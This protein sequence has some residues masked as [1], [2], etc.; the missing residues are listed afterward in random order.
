MMDLVDGMDQDIATLD[1]LQLLGANTKYTSLEMWASVVA[2]LVPLLTLC[3]SRLGQGFQYIQV[4]IHPVIE[5]LRFLLNLVLGRTRLRHLL[6]D[7]TWKLDNR[8]E[9]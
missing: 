7:S 2:R 1:S 5:S 8:N 6:V 4:S 3:H 9:G